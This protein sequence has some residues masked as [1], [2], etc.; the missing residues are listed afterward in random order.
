M[1][2]IFTANT[3]FE[4]QLIRNQFDFAG[5]ETQVR[6]EFAGGAMGELPVWDCWPELWLLDES[7]LDK[8]RAI[9][10]LFSPTSDAERPEIRCTICGNACP[11]NFQRCWHCQAPLIVC[12]E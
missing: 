1:I 10:A 4:L 11:G 6:N 9:V 8:A 5:L 12:E 2:K 7:K 3:L